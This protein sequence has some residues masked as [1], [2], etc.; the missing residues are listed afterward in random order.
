MKVDPEEGAFHRAN[1]AEEHFRGGLNIFE[2][3]M[4]ESSLDLFV[5]LFSTWE[6]RTINVYVGTGPLVLNLILFWDPYI[7]REV[8]PLVLLSSVF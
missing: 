8:K 4:S 5:L 1:D 2:K 7:I 6:I 3:E